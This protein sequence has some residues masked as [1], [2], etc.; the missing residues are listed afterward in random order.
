[1]GNEETSQKMA[2]ASENKDDRILLKLPAQFN[3]EVQ[4]EF[5]KSYEQHEKSHSFMLDFSSVS[6]IDSSGL[7]MLLLL[8]D[9]LGNANNDEKKQRLHFI[10]CKV[11]IQKIFQ[12]SNFDKLFT[13]S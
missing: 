13:I 5:R 9:Y 2:I 8:H 1:M 10:N 3:Y 7:G 4:S 6:Y 11:E 12:I